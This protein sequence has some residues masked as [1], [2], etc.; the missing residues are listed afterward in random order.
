MLDRIPDLYPLDIKMSVD[1]AESSPGAK[2]CCALPLAPQPSGTPDTGT[3]VALSL[4]ESTSSHLKTKP[5]TRAIF[6]GFHFVLQGLKN[7][8]S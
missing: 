2:S 8:N 7:V 4:S 3:E 5:Q 6:G 1:I